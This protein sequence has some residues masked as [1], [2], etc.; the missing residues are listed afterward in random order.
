MFTA[1]AQHR[2]WRSHAL[3]VARVVMGGVFLT[4]AYMKFTGIDVTAGYIASAGF[5]FP[6]A[7]AWVAAFSELALGLA[8]VTGAYFSEAALLLAAYVL[9][10]AFTFYGP[11]KWGTGQYEFGL[12]VNHFTMVAGLLF[13]VAHGPGDTW[14]IG[15]IF[16][17]KSQI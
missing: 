7:L 11:S 10:L 13:M 1:I 12:F 4:A 8:L 5:P 14:Q 16:S 9:F 15:K 17:A 3:L 2:F 6:L